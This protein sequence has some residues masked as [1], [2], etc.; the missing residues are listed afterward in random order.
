MKQG[1]YQVQA[2]R[3]N[4]STEA[5]HP[6]VRHLGNKKVEGATAPQ[7]DI[8]SSHIQKGR[9]VD[10]EVVDEEQE[11]SEEDRISNINSWNHVQ[12]KG[13]GKWSQILKGNKDSE[14]V[15]KQGER[16]PHNQRRPKL[17][18]TDQFLGVFL[19]PDP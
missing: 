8:R 12:K 5:N 15:A 13:F 18:E 16:K 1:L 7:K 10:I 14:N 4:L 11:E 3:N 2:E 6:M 9:I 17:N 19:Q